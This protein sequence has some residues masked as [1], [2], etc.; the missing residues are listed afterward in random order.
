M[1]RL[2]LGCLSSVVRVLVL[3]LRTGPVHRFKTGDDMRIWIGSIPILLLAPIASAGSILG[4]LHDDLAVDGNLVVLCRADRPEGPVSRS[5]KAVS[6]YCDGQ[7]TASFRFSD[8]NPGSYRVIIGGMGVSRVEWR[9]VVIES[10]DDERV[11]VIGRR[12]DGGST[13]EIRL[14]DIATEQPVAGAVVDLTLL[15][16]RV[17]TKATDRSGLVT[18]DSLRPGRY[19]IR[20]VDSQGRRFPVHPIATSPLV[21]VSDQFETIRVSDSQAWQSPV[22]LQG[23]YLCKG[24]L[25]AGLRVR[26][27]SGREAA[28]DSTGRFEI[29][30]GR[31]EVIDL[32]DGD[33]R[34]LDRKNAFLVFYCEEFPRER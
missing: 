20:C 17:E 21:V 7:F 25:P 27:T 11:L 12:V 1:L 14:V 23:H 34:V 13:V 5:T 29:E 8:V 32:I 31:W 10:P 15:G 6:E 24:E 22:R 16:H 19:G 18:F 9:D 28:L 4:S 3:R 30:A 26:T 33:G 2:D